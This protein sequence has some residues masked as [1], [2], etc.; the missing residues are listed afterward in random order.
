MRDGHLNI[1]KQC[2]RT[3]VTKYR[4][5]NIEQIREY[6]IQRY[7]IP[8]RKLSSKSKCQRDRANQPD[9]YKARM[10]VGNALRDGYLTKQP[11]R[12]CGRLDVHGH[13]TDYSQ[14][15]NVIWLCPVC[16]SA[17]H[18]RMKLLAK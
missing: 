18:K 16:H 3:R 9:K 1:C 15:L 5:Q 4:C 11:C 17:E 12:D 8:N 2:T 10:I 6:D 14:P 7:Q 13:H